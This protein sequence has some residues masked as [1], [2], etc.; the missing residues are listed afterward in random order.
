MATNRFHA[1]ATCVHFSAIKT[2]NKMN[3][4]CSRLGYET[5][6][7]YQFRCWEPKDHVKKLIQKEKK[8]RGGK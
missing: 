2:A 7:S 1:C 3:Y 8:E 5:Q 4:K 6:P